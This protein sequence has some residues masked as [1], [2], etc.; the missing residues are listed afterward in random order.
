[1]KKVL[2]ADAKRIADEYGVWYNNNDPDRK[3]KLSELLRGYDIKIVEGAMS[4]IKYRYGE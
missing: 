4:L 3:K 2:I 1:M